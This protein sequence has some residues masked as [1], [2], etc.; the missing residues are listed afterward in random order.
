M[1]RVYGDDGKAPGDRVFLPDRAA[2]STASCRVDPERE[3]RWTVYA[4]L[5]ARLQ[6]G[7]V[8]RCCTRL[9][10]LQGSLPLNPDGHA[11]GRPAPVVQH[12]GQLHDQHQLADLRRRDDHEPP[13]PDDRPGGAELR[14]RGRRHGRRWPR[15]SAA[16]PAGGPRRSATSGSTSPAP[17]VRILLPLS[18]VVALVL[19]SQGVIQNFHGYTDGRRRSRAPRQMH[20][21]RAG[22]QPDRHQAAR[23]ERRRLLQRQLRRTRSRTRTPFNNFVEML[24]DPASSRSPWPSRSGAWSGTAARA[25][26]CSPSCSSIWVGAVAGRHGAR[27]QRQPAARRRSAPTRRSTADAAAAATW[28]ARRSASDRPRRGCGRRRRPAP[29]TARS[30]RCTTATR[31]SAAASPLA[32]MMLGEVSPGGVGVGLNGLLIMVILSVFIAGLMVGRT[33]E[34]LGKKIQAAEMKMVVLYILA[35]PRRVLGFAA[36]SVLA[37]L[38]ARRRCQPRAARPHRDPLR[39]HLGGQ[40]QRL[41]V[42]RPHRRHPVVRHDARARHARRPLLPH[43]PGARHRRLA[44]PQAA[45]A[46]DRP[47]RSRPTRRC[48]AAW[49]SAWSSIVAGL[50]FF[51]AL[52]LGP[53]VEQLSP[54]GAPA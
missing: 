6:R 51:P 2:R 21:R 25:G 15:S 9:Q 47:G 41:G 27:G 28:R 53:I 30:T 45:G 10:R 24:G 11:G 33:P 39:L 16:W 29:R 19:V 3:Q 37:R 40:Q 43:H 5:A 17:T 50:T 22:R 36:A 18:F 49:S 35:M 38:G 14:V 34:Y 4:L 12:R 42:R 13:H 23:H 44:G 31:R 7:L 54:L 48:S 52:A 20:P 8:P 32:H 1:A 26:P 46:G